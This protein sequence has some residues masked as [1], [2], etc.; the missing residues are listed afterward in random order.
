MHYNTEA[1]RQRALSLRLVESAKSDRSQREHENCMRVTRNAAGLIIHC[2]SCEEAHADLTFSGMIHTEEDQ[3]E[4]IERTNETQG[5][6]C[7]RCGSV[8]TS[9]VDDHMTCLKCDAVK[10]V[11]DFEFGEAKLH[12]GPKWD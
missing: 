4:P 10:H 1:D 3:F 12:F 6:P 11:Y 7:D 8:E 5:A 2:Y 9:F